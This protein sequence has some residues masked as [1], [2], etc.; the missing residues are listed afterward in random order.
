MD[1]RLAKL[2]QVR[3]LAEEMARELQSAHPWRRK[4]WQDEQ[5]S[6]RAA[7]TEAQLSLLCDL[8]RPASRDALA[9][10]GEAHDG[11][12][13]SIPG[14]DRK[15]WVSR[16]WN[17]MRDDPSALAEELLVVLGGEE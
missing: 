3:A 14:H 11:R 2:P 9:R 15:E 16:G 1:D 13:E 4:P 17:H 7:D 10:L 8:S 12:W 5:P 6:M